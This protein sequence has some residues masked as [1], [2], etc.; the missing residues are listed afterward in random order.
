MV[1]GTSHYVYSTRLDLLCNNM[2]HL[3][4]GGSHSFPDND[5][6]PPPGVVCA[7]RAERLGTQSHGRAG[8]AQMHHH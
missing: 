4:A 8:A 6:A 5:G 3:L 7:G 2:L 1:G